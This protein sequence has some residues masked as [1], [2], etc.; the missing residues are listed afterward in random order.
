MTVVMRMIAIMT[1]ILNC[2]IYEMWA[3]EDIEEI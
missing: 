3:R 2:F 1:M